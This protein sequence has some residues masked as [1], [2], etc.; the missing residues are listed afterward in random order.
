M[1]NAMKILVA[2]SD[3]DEKKSLA[4]ALGAQELDVIFTE[5]V[6]QARQVLGNEQVVIVF[7]QPELADGSFP[8]LLN[9]SKPT[10]KSVPV[11]VCSPFYDKDVYVDAMCRGAYDFVSYPYAREEVVWIVSGALHVV[12]AGHA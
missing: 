6:Q 10:S 2:L 3:V 11:V 5:N 12:A 9:P 8:D 1:L 7:C 4:D